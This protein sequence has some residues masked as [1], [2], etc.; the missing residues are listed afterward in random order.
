MSM[1]LLELVQRTASK[2]AMPK[3]NSVAS[4]D[5]PTWQQML[6][7][8]Q[9]ETD[10]LIDVQH[11]WSMLLKTW[12]ITVTSLNFHSEPVPDGFIR[13]TRDAR[14]FRTLTRTP[15]AGPASADEWQEL[16]I[17]GIGYYP[18]AWRMFS[19]PG[20]GVAINIFGIASGETVQT[21]YLSNVCIINGTK[22]VKAEWSAD[23]DTS[24]FPDNLLRLGLTWRWKRAKGFDYSEERDQYDR[25]LE[26]AIANDTGMRRIS[27][28]SA[29]RRTDGI[30]YWSGPVMVTP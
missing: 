26:T 15:L 1:T 7:L 24:L 12:V 22:G 18:G 6:E 20:T 19:N 30:G 27:T 23:D 21:E 13:L 9:D 29:D 4:S 28:S 11:D 17:T 10:S 25:A 2:L 8:L 5:D 16:T 3:P 14:V